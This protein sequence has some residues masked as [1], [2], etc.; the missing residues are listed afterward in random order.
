MRWDGAAGT[1]STWSLQ[2]RSREAHGEEGAQQEEGSRL[3][4]NPEVIK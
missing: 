4:E 2:L 3:K 1:G